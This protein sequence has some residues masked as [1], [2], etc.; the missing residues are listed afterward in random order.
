MSEAKRTTRGRA[1][2]VDLLPDEIRSALH[3]MLRDKR[4]TQTDIR[5]AVN[6]LIDE[7]GLP[8]ELKLSRSGL[9]RYASNMEQVGSRIREAREVSKQ[10]VAKLGAEP[11]GDVSRV[12]VEMVRTLA[13]DSVIK[14]SESEKPLE[15]KFIKELAIGIERLEKAAS[16]SQKRELEIRKQIAA[17][18]ADAVDS[19]VKQAGLTAD[20]IADIKRQ[21]LGI[22]G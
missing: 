2:K 17:E 3:A 13:F 7:H 6:E 9:N 20:T 4:H 1:S 5:E 8:D 11:E 16:E 15:P 22:A 18:T 12:L 10:W 19:I 21:I 14:M